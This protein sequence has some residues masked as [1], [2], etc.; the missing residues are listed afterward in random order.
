LLSGWFRNTTS[1]IVLLLS[2][3]PC[4]SCFMTLSYT[5]SISTVEFVL[6]TIL[7]LWRPVQS[8]SHRVAL[9][10]HLL[11][12]LSSRSINCETSGL[13]TM[14]DSV[15]VVPL[16]GAL[17]VAFVP[18]RRSFGSC[19]ANWVH[20]LP[21]VGYGSWTVAS[22]AI[23]C[24]NC[25]ASNTETNFLR[26]CPH[27]LGELVWCSSDCSVLRFMCSKVI[28]SWTCIPCISGKARG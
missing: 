3:I 16:C 9:I 20:I 25:V 10:Q 11:K 19:D 1:E 17:V 4:V 23:P 24:Y 26:I 13:N 14:D 15:S 21:K 7:V 6:A 22:L 2:T 5:E 8:A 18:P 27:K 28:L 12:S